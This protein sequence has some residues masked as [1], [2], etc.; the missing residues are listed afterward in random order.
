MPQNRLARRWRKLRRDPIRYFADS[1]H[2]PLRVGALGSMAL[3]TCL[4]DCLC[5]PLRTLRCLGASV[6]PRR[7]RLVPNPDLIASPEGW[8]SRGENPRFAV[9]SKPGLRQGGWTLLVLKVADRGIRLDPLIYAEGGQGCEGETAVRLPSLVSGAVRCL[10]RLPPRVD[11]LGFR[12]LSGPG[13]FRIEHFDVRPVTAFGAY[14]HL[15]R[16]EGKSLPEALRI[17]RKPGPRHPPKRATRRRS[18]KEQRASLELLRQSP[19]FDAEHYLDRN[20]DVA[21]AGLDPSEHY[22]LYGAAE[23]RDP[24]PAF[25]TLFYLT[26]NPD[27]AES[28]FNPLVHYIRYGEKEGRRPTPDASTLR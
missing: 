1:H 8:E 22:Y 23:G 3:I 17:L 10:V 15:R 9:K 6:M 18:K 11:A 20:E 7:S 19:W 24:G 26:S 28:G 13:R 12:P 4:A 25:D 21:E 27:V 14:R 5:S 2:A 16:S